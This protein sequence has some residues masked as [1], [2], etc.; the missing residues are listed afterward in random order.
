MSDTATRPVISVLM[1]VY[2]GVRYLGEAIDG[3]LAQTLTDFELIIINDGSRDGSE[4]LI[5][6]YRDPRIPASAGFPPCGPV[7]G[8]RGGHAGRGRRHSAQNPPPKALPLQPDGRIICHT[9][10]EPHDV[11]AHTFGFRAEYDQVCLE[12]QKRH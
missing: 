1:P 9:C 4:A 2:N 11:N 6:G 10:H 8:G 5:A 7:E 3:V 12:C